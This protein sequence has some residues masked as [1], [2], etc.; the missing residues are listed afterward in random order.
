MNDGTV[1]EKSTFVAAR[2]SQT[3]SGVCTVGGEAGLNA[4][5]MRPFIG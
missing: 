2:P 4:A 1:K 5:T 3:A